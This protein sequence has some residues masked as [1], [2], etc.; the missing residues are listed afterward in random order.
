MKLQLIALV[1]VLTACSNRH[2]DEVKEKTADQ[3]AHKAHL[4]V[5]R[6]TGCHYLSTANSRSLTPR[7]ATD[8]H[9][10]ICRA[11]DITAK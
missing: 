6:G 8:G 3:D 9:T 10:H 5:D 11:Q 7:I 2:A 1:F 4:Y